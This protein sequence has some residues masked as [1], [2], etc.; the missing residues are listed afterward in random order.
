VID[1]IPRAPA[2]VA[3]RRIHGLWADRRRLGEMVDGIVRHSH[4]PLAD[5]LARDLARLDG[6]LDGL[7]ALV[8][9][10]VDADTWA[11]LDGARDEVTGLCGVVLR[12]LGGLA[13]GE[14]VPDGRGQAWVDELRERAGVSAPLVVLPAVPT[15]EEQPG[16][17][18]LPFPGADLWRL[19]LLAEAVAREIGDEP[20]IAREAAAVAEGPDLR[21]VL[22]DVIATALVGPAYPIAFTVLDH[23]L[24]LGS[25]RRIGAMLQTLRCMDA[26][27]R[28]TRHHLGP[29]TAVI[30][31]LADLAADAQA[32]PEVDDLYH[33][34]VSPRL[35]P[36]LRAAGAA[37]RWATAR[38]AAWDGGP[39]PGPAPAGPAPGWLPVLDATWLAKLLRP[40]ADDLLKRAAD[41]L[42]DGRHPLVPEADRRLRADDVAALR[43]C[44]LERGWYELRDLLRDDRVP[45][46][47]R[48]A[49]TGRFMRLLSEQLQRIADARSE[50]A[51][52]RGGPRAWETLR[53]LEHGARPARREA[54]EY[55]GASLLMSGGGEAAGTLVVDLADGMLARYSECTGLGQGARAIP[56]P[57]PMLETATDVVR[58]PFPDPSAW[59]VVLVAHE[60]G[61]LVARDTPRFA[62]WRIGRI[63]RLPL[64]ALPPATANAWLEEL[65]ADV[66]ATFTAGPAF[67][68]AALELHFTPAGADLPRGD[69]PSHAIRVATL[70]ATLR[71]MNDQDRPTPH[72]VGAYGAVVAAL[73][74]TWAAA[75]A[76]AGQVRRPLDPSWDDLARE[77]FGLV[78]TDYRLGAAYRPERWAAVAELAAG[79]ADEGMAGPLTPLAD[80]SPD[81]ALGALWLARAGSATPLDTLERVSRRWLTRL[82]RRSDDD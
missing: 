74:G 45:G 69:H 80:V 26:A 51:A 25:E 17:V 35:A 62:T 6:T 47:V 30:A 57:A 24:V 29:Y 16:V 65:F 14:A 41:D 3:Q 70:L 55:L 60:F 28:G 11:A 67:V 13:V 10:P 38:C 20:D 40:D 31:Q 21:A 44:R 7:T 63:A 71:A 27:E 8:A 79:G 73:E 32:T 5:G 33:E 54:L 22:T 61:H 72:H 78:R 46:R 77:L 37:W 68:C 42:L 58:V 52:A 56:A 76:T 23:R 9:Q 4:P 66:F 43:L 75:L 36:A 48:S 64:S 15:D 2:E 18:A 49:V 59:S 1:L 39:A 12:L 34:V 82:L 50:I 53:T 81:D 19:P